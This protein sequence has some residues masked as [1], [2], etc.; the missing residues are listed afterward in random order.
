[1]AEW[2]DNEVAVHLTSLGMVGASIVL[3]ALGLKASSEESERGVW[4]IFAIA[5][6]FFLG[7]IALSA[8]R[9]LN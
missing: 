1:M 4:V 9:L 7:A 2:W 5:A 6:A 8:I 3:L